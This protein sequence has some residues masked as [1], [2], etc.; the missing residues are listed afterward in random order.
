M[1]CLI[2]LLNLKGKTL[3]VVKTC[4]GTRALGMLLFAGAFP[5]ARSISRCKDPVESPGCSKARR[6]TQDSADF[7]RYSPINVDG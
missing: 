7:G 3:S 1:I 5:D 2:L 4:R 6:E